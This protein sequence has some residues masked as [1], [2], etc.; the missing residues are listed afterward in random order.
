MFTLDQPSFPHILGLLA[1]ISYVMTLLP[2]LLRIVFPQTRKTGIPKFLLKQRRL[3]G[4][5]AF[6]F[7]TGHGYFLIRQRS[8]DFFDFKT[9]WIYIQGVVTFTIFTLLTLTSNDW[10]I[11]KLKKNWKKLHQLTYIAIFL[12]TWHVWDKMSGHWTFVTPIAMILMSGTTVLFFVRLWIENKPK[13]K[14]Q[15]PINSSP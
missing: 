14:T 3:T 5:F 6:I 7:A 15:P 10:S 1:L 2:T 4:I 8:I 11:K 13:Q 9:S 12:L